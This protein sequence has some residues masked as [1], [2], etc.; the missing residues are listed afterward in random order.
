MIPAALLSQPNHRGEYR[1]IRRLF[2]MTL[3][4]LVEFR[5]QGIPGTVYLTPQARLSA[6]C[7]VIRPLHHYL[8]RD[9]LR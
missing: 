9:L 2:A 3:V 1:K 4:A 5:G 7:Q 6:N 8:S